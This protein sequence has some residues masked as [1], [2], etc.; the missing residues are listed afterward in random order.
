ML[1]QGFQSPSIPE[2]V[3]NAQQVQ[4]VMGMRPEMQSG[5]TAQEAHN[6]GV[7]RLQSPSPPE[8]GGG[9]QQLQVGMVMMLEM[10]FGEELRDK[11]ARLKAPINPMLDKFVLQGNK[12]N[13][14]VK[15]PSNWV[16]FFTLM[17]MSPEKFGWARDFLASGAATHLEE[18]LGT[19]S[20][21]ILDEGPA[22]SNVL[23]HS[24]NMTMDPA[25]IDAEDVNVECHDA[26]NQDANGSS[27]MELSPLADG[28]KKKKNL[29]RP[30][31]VVESEVRRSDRLKHNNMGFKSSS[32]S[33]KNVP[34]MILLHQLCPIK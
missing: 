19:V 9:T 11:E 2:H 33:S 26:P 3:T 27:I 34:P 17:L 18:N 12:K 31:P 23:C 21:P 8:H 15:I 28:S 32:C 6:V 16:Q 1:S 20:L 5:V 30:T 14:I 4:V 22:N 25:D 10:Q 13:L 24:D 29:K 7:H